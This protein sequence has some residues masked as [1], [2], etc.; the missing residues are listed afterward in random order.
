LAGAIDVLIKVSK[1][2]QLAGHVYKGASYKNKSVYIDVYL[3][4]KRKPLNLLK[5]R[6]ELSRHRHIG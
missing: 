4:A 2:D 6:N 3:T 1:E 5:L